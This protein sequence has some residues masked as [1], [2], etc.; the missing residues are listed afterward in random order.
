MRTYGRVYE[1][2]AAG[3]AVPGTGKW[4]VVETDAQGYNDAVNVTWMAQVLQLNINESPFYADWG[5]N[6][7]EAIVQQIFPDYYMT[8][9]QQRFSPYF[10]SVIISKQ[11]A[12]APTYRAD[13]TTSRGQKLVAQVAV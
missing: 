11:D 9:T 12:A 6:A 4:V 8:L 2:D 10:A 5:I 3:V 7:R 13:V 1:R